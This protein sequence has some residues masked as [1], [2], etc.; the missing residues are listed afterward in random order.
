MTRIALL[1]LPALLVLNLGCGGQTDPN[2]GIP[3]DKVAPE[4]V[5]DTPG[6]AEA[7]GGGQK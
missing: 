1:I 4:N 6:Y 2:A 7:M 3:P 5:E